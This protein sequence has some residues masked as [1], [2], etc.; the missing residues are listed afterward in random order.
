MEYRVLS[1][2]DEE[3]FIEISKNTFRTRIELNWSPDED[4]TGIAVGCNYNF[5]GHPVGFLKD[6]GLIV[7]QIDGRRNRGIF[8]ISDTNTIIQA[9]PSL[10]IDKE[11]QK[12]FKK[13]GFATHYIL[14]GLHSHLGKKKSGNYVVGFTKKK[15]FNQMIKKYQELNAEDAIKLPGLKSCSFLF[16][17]KARTYQEGVFPIP[18]A[19]IFES[20]ADEFGNI[21]SDISEP[22]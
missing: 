16:K 8:E 3:C 7:S 4:F 22:I 10:V 17:T 19:L 15:T 13:E 5:K 2:S 6:N 21:F 18:V 11:P 1:F 12:D 14:S 9:G 20:R